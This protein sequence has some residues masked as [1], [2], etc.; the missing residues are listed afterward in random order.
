MA[1]D[2]IP[3]ITALDNVPSSLRDAVVA[4]GNFDGVHRGHRAVLDV[5]LQQARDA[6]VPALLLTFEPHPRTVFNPQKPVFRL[7]P[8]PLKAELAG[9]LGFTATV[10]LPFDRTFAQQSP[11]T[12]VTDILVNALGISKVVTGFNFHFGRAREGSPAFLQRAGAE[13]GFAVTVVEPF[14]DEGAELVSSSRIRTC[15]RDGE[16]AE[17]A[18]LLGYHYT[19]RCEILKGEQLGRKLGFPTANMALPAEADLRTGIYAVRF[20]RADGSLRDGV[21]N[22]GFRPTVNETGSPLLETFIFD[23][24]SLIY[25]ETCSVIFFA[26]LRNEEKYADLDE[27]VEQ[28]KRDSEQARAVLA[29]LRPLGELDRALAFA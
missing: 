20:K 13:H 21:A 6:G 28:M 10:E 17:A 29:D 22:F 9:L 2:P 25:G 11:E 23:F 5:A 3:R 15:L 19:V 12:F 24:D 18:G 16:I 26:H 7:T 8:A 27:M 1:S 14:Q 4:I